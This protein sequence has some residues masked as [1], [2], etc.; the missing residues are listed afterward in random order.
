MDLP[1]TQVLVE[2]VQAGSAD[3]LE[4]LCRRY[5]QRILSAVRLRLGPGLRRKVE[6]LDIVQAAMIDVFRGIESF[7]FR[8]EGAFLKYVNHLVENSVRD[9]AKHWGAQRRDV[10]REQAN[11]ADGDGTAWQH[12]EQ[13]ADRRTASPSR[14]AIL[15]EDYAL[16]ERA[17]D[18]LA[19]R[20]PEQREL[21]I[22]VKLEGRSYEELAEEHGATIDAI[23]MRVQRAMN[24]LTKIYRSLNSNCEDINE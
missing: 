12:T 10:R 20:S 15:R 19:D 11:A 3:A 5:E 9:A 14:I 6:S 22:A 16:L 4:E 24:T 18:I 17:L 8:T 13:L 21:L 1:V 2:R 7:E 23:R